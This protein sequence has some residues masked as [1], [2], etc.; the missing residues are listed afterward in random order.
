[1]EDFMRD[2]NPDRE[3]QVWEGMA[4]PYRAFTE[5]HKLSLAGKK[6]V[7][8]IVMLRSSVS[9]E[10]TLQKSELKILTKADAR[11]I[12]ANYHEAPKPIRVMKK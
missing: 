11:E 3:I 1:M 4:K 12:L 8:Q 5:K 2:Q 7:F 10:E 9:D 6:E